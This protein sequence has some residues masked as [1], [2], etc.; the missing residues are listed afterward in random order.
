LRKH[1]RAE[2]DLARDQITGLAMGKLALAIQAREAWAICFWLKCRAGWQER[3]ALQVTGE[4]SLVEILKRRQ[5]KL[6][7]DS[8]PQAER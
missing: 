1:F 4:V 6:Q 3:Q 8:K 2:L 7:H 5:A